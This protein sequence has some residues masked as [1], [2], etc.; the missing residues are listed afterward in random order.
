M[1]EKK[2]VKS[3]REFTKQS[4]KDNER[5]QRLEKEKEEYRNQ[6]ENDKENKD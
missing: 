5:I 2:E 4:K 1:T 6:K 3:Q